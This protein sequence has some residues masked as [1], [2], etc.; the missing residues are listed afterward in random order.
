MLIRVLR[1]NTYLVA[2]L[3][4]VAGCQT[5]ES[6]H[7]RQVST[8]R[9]HLEVFADSSGSNKSVSIGRA[10]PMTMIIQKEPF[11]SESEVVS[12]H[13]VED[14]GGFT[15]QIQMD[16]HGT[17]VLEM[18]TAS[19]PGKHLAIFCEFGEKLDKAR[20][21]AAP[22]INRRISNGLLIFTPDADREEAA[23][24]ELGFNNLARKTQPSLKGEK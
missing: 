13:V 7:K 5:P 2:L 16:E 10:S 20:W 1:Y 8:L 21:L 17:R 6:K 12:A 4:C 19:Y 24:I 11:I 3:I 9:V 22:K 15:L 18:F 14:Q 23:Q